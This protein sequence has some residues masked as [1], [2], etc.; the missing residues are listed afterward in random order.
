M[1]KVSKDVKSGECGNCANVYQRCFKI[2]L[3]LSVKIPE[4][5]KI[6]KRF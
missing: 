4:K 3:S 5:L 6:E 1:Y 2:T